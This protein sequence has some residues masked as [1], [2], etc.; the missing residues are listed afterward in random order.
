MSHFGW[1]LKT[2]I[3]AILSLTLSVSAP[4]FFGDRPFDNPNYAAS[5]R[6]ALRISP[7]AAPNNQVGGC[8]PASLV[9]HS[10]PALAPF[11]SAPIY[12]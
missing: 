8:H 10:T 4:N 6:V 3:I 1:N 9:R 5:V 2:R 12:L 11:F 7:L